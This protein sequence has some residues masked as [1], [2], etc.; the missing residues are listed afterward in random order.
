MRQQN[1]RGAPVDFIDE[2]YES[3]IKAKELFEVL[4]TETIESLLLPLSYLTVAPLKGKDRSFEK[5]RDDYES[6]EPG[7]GVRWLWDIVRGCITCDTEDEI[8]TLL[9]YLD[10]SCRNLEIVRLKN[11]FATPTPGGFRDINMNIRIQIG[12]N[13]DGD[14]IY[15]ICELQIHCRFWAKNP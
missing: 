5:A 4:M 10:R 9:D 7:F 15:H 13:G 11:R 14:G 6:R 8:L 2:L 3:A 1:L 12:R